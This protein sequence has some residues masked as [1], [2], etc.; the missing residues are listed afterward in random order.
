M[1]KLTIK[2]LAAI[3]E[4]AATQSFTVAAARLHTAQS[5]LSKSIQEAES[6]LGVKLFDRTTKTVSLTDVGRDFSRVVVRMLD[7]LESEIDNVNA[8]GRVVAGSLSIGVTPLLAATL[9]PPVFAAYAGRFPEVALRVEDDATDILFNKLM[10]REVDLA[11]GTFES[12]VPGVSLLPLFDDPLVLLSHPS[13]GL[14]PKVAWDELSRQR[15]VGMTW[16]SSVGRI[17]D[18]TH[19]EVRRKKLRI[20]AQSR[21]WLTVVS[22]ADSLRAVCVVPTYALALPQAQALR[23]SALVKPKVTRTVYAASLKNREPS[24]AAHS[25]LALLTETF[26]QTSSPFWVR[27]PISKRDKSI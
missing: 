9:L 20:V 16:N 12:R 24:A 3:R 17:I 15:V 11:I 4:L 21:H 27:R 13:L 2:Q 7:D 25:F 8:I 10:G 14:G 22:L 19:W 18:N 23:Q 6:I 1:I 26:Q 5:N